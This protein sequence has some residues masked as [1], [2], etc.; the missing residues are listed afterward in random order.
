MT[1]NTEKA[2]FTILSHVSPLNDDEPA[3]W[4]TYP[5]RGESHT[6]FVRAKFLG[7]DEEDT[8]IYYI[9]PLRSFI[10]PNDEADAFA[11]QYADR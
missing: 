7:R 3:P 1:S 8:I 4:G 5:V 10:K 6:V 2:L 9:D 11:A